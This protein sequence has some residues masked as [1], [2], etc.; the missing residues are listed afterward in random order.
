ML[1][2]IVHGDFLERRVPE[3]ARALKDIALSGN[4]EPT[5]SPHFG[6]AIEVIA[7]ALDHFEL[8]GRVKVVLITNGSMLAKPKIQRA[9]RR[10]GQLDGQIWF[11][12]DTATAE[13]MERINGSQAA[14]EQQLA[15]LRSV[16]GTCDTLIQTCWFA[17]DG[18]PPSADELQ[19]YLDCLRGLARSSDAPSGVLL[20]TLARPSQQP[21]AAR[22]TALSHEW[23]EDFGHRIEGTS[24]AVKVID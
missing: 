1:R 23:L 6:E 2:D 4:G 10:L 19:A 12:L 3:P 5:T 17:Q 22:L 14:V 16:A 8:L 11:K 13:G 15:R 18:Q 21:G 20:Y 7:E 9:V 24:M